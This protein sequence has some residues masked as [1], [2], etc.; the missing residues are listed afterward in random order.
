MRQ[1][2][3]AFIAGCGG[4]FILH[5]M[6]DVYCEATY[7]AIGHAYCNGAP[8]KRQQAA[9]GSRWVRGMVSES[10]RASTKK[11]EDHEMKNKELERHLFV[12]C[13]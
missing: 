10:Q 8:P 4:F 6:R 5:S 9:A 13:S 12:F 11:H 3:K 1:K 2:G 7:A